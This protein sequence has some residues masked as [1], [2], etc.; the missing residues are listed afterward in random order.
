MRD[1]MHSEFLGLRRSLIN[2]L[3]CD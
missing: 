1:F 3:P 2:K